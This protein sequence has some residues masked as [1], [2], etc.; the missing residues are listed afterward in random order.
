MPKTT[1]RAAA[2]AMSPSP[3]ACGALST[4][5]ATRQH[6]PRPQMPMTDEKAATGQLPDT[7]QP[8]RLWQPGQSLHWQETPK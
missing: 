5:A 7:T 2:S 8:T 1:N 3:I 6:N 4:W